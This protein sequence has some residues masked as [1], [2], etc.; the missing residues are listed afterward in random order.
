MKLTSPKDV[1]DWCRENG[2]HPSR[3]L[4]QNFLID[5]NSLDAIIATSGAAAGQN[6]LE[7]GPGLGVLTEALLQTGAR[8]TAIEKDRRLAAFLRATLAPQ[9]PGR[10]TLIEGDALKWIKSDFPVETSLLD[11]G[12]SGVVSNLPYSVGTRILVELALH[13]LAPAAFTLLLQTEVAERLAAPENHPERALLSVW[14]QRLYDVR[15]ARKIPPACF[16]PRPEVDSSLVRLT[17]HGRH[18]L[19]PPQAVFFAALT[20]HAFTHRRKQLLPLLRTLPGL[21]ADPASLL[22]SLGIDPKTRP[23][24]LGVAEWCA[25]AG[26]GLSCP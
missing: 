7:V 16:Y 18:P 24:Q 14:I 26:R 5:H 20:R 3:A 25:L 8:V 13:P 2:F 6:I 23:E 21:R 15:L 9:F 12:Y 1:R 22:A 4:G 11:I 19:A 17:R 10:L